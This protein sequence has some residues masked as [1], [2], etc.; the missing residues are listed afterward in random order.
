MGTDE[1]MSGV[2][3][4]TI[5]SPLSPTSGRSLFPFPMIS[6][7]YSDSLLDRSLDSTSKNAAESA[8]I[9]RLIKELTPRD[10]VTTIGKARALVEYIAAEDLESAKVIAKE[11][12]RVSPEEVNE[13]A[14]RYHPRKASEIQETYST[15]LRRISVDHYFEDKSPSPD[16]FQKLLTACTT[17]VKE[18]IRGRSNSGVLFCFAEICRRKSQPFMQFFEEKHSSDVDDVLIQITESTDFYLSYEEKYQIIRF[19]NKRKQMEKAH[20]YRKKMR[21]A[22]AKDTC[23]SVS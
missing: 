14:K 18:E 4:G 15:V 3:F 8:E 13:S 5:Q 20:R 7:V 11:G 9:N 2:L 17:P 12:R 6:S 23:C 10:L 21:S 22:A 19:N 1:E 16:T